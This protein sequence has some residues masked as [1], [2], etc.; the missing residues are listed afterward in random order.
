MNEKYGYFQTFTF[1]T[2][3]RPSEAAKELIDVALS[4]SGQD[5]MREKGMI[6]ILPH[7]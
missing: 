2:K 7:E 6:P 4:S 3:G 5:I 1:V